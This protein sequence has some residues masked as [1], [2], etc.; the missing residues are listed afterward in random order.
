MI[1]QNLLN[2]TGFACQPLN[3]QGTLARINTPFCFADGDPVPVYLSL[4]HI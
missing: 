3:E 4:I 2:L 1:C